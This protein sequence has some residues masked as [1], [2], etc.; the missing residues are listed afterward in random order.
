MRPA[1]LRG[2]GTRSAS[3]RGA[4]VEGSVREVSGEVAPS[5]ASAKGCSALVRGGRS[6][7]RARRDRCGSDLPLGSRATTGWGGDELR[8][9]KT[10]FPRG[11]GEQSPHK[12]PDEAPRLDRI[13]F[14]PSSVESFSVQ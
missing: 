3:V 14:V 8:G 1:I 7:S 12:N 10:W 6:I 9:D 13:G 11:S 5:G 4:P 2:A